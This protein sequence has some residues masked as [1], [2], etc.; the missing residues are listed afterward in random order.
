MPLH[1]AVIG[2][3]ASGMSAASRVKRLLRDRAEVVVFE[4]GRW[5][6]FALCGAPYYISCEVGSLEELIHYPLSE[7]IEKRGI[8]VS[9]ETY[10]YDIEAEDRVIHWQR[11][12][13]SKG[14]Y[15][16][17]YLVLATGA[18]PI[19][20]TAWMQYENV[21]A[22]HSLDDAE[23]IRQYLARSHVRRVAI[24]GLG[25]IGYE[26]AE[27]VKK[28]GKEVVIIEACNSPLPKAL[29]ED[30]AGYVTDHLRTQG[31]H[32]V[33]GRKVECVEGRDCIASEVMLEGGEHIKADALIV[34]MGIKPRVEL[35]KRAGLK[36]G[37][38]GAIWVDEKLRTSR[39][40]I[41]AVGDVVETV[42][43]VTGERTWAPFAPIANKMGYVAGS[44]IA[45]H[46]MIFPG[47]VR[48]SVTCAFGLVVATTGLT[49]REAVEKGYDVVSVMIKSRTKPRYISED[50]RIWIKIVADRSTG[51][52]LGAQAIG[53]ESAFWRVNIV[54][55]LLMKGGKVEDLFYCD[56]GYMPLLSTAW[57]PLVIAARRLFHL[58]APKSS[59]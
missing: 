51:K 43:L 25:Y 2:G 12:D 56:W 8:R 33:L 10:V 58:L 34:A 35:A 37:K 20:P 49:E 17:D 59:R 26:L 53:D 6:S 23:R 19:V 30:M 54:A 40:E 41:Y 16:Y 1:V 48:T 42:D 45:G 46:D 21:F 11:R 31:V 57:D 29:D 36:L 22:I 15:E 44:N 38:T 18:E 50:T 3:G 28:L 55:T 32:L 24:I 27:S 52:L 13:G 7:F 4:K 14:T 9:L 47:V 39:K 5:V